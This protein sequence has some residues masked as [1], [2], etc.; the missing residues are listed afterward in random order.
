MAR[1]LRT[2]MFGIGRLRTALVAV[3]VVAGLGAGVVA[4]NTEQP[5]LAAG[6]EYTLVGHGF[7]HGRGMGQWGAFGYARTGWTAERILSHF[8]GG[9]TAGKVGDSE[10]P[11]TLTGKSSVVVHADAGA[12]VGSERV[13]PGQAV[14]LSG[15]TATITSGCGGAVVKT[16]PATEVSPITPGS[17][18]P[19]AELLKFCGAG[20]AYRG[21]LTL[22]GGAV[23]NKVSIEDYVA[24]GTA[25]ESYP[26]WA[27]QGGFEAL[28]AQAV[29]IRSYILAAIEQRRPITDTQSTLVYE[30][31]KGEDPRASRAAAATAGQVRVRDG[32]PVLAEFSASS[33]GW[34]AGGEF[35]AVE[36][37]GDVASPYHDWQ[38]TGSAS[39]FG[40]K[41]GVGEL[42]DLSVVTANGLGPD[43][44]RAIKVRAVGTGGTVELS[45]AE[46]RTLLGLRSDFFA[47]RG[48]ATPPAIEKPQTSPGAP[49]SPGAP[50]SLDLLSRLL[51]VAQ[52]AILGQFTDLGGAAGPLGELLG[53]LLPLPNKAGAVQ[54]FEHG[55]ITYDESGRTRVT[56]P[57][58]P[59]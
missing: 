46:V 34:S 5:D 32:K 54:R 16:V 53:P 36:D 27:D 28:K 35:P 48:Q 49:A 24:G 9:T 3:P 38:V 13:A 45:G 11:V 1:R 47:V 51:M 30:G 26:A 44:G 7:G 18:R 19:A 29:A 14:A 52:Q 43:H 4:L 17:G 22:V 50:G 10:I 55:Q 25:V 20:D 15:G 40:G 21:S 39:L 56:L 58:P 59:R 12:V 23:V 31:V 6:S 37:T 42:T 33:G 2:R 8:Y 57:A 41:L